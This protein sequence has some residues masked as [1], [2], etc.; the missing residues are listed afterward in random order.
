MPASPSSILG[1][2]DPAWPS[3]HAAN[4]IT[5]V[6]TYSESLQSQLQYHR[7]ATSRVLTE[8]Q[9][10]DSERLVRNLHGSFA[11]VYDTVV[12]LYQADMFW[13]V[14]GVERPNGKREDYASP[15][16]M[17]DLAEVWLAVIDRMI[18]FAASLSESEWERKIAYKSMAGVG[19]ESP[20][21]QMVV[22]V[23]NHGTHHRGQVTSMIRQLGEKP[24][25]L[26]LIAFY[27]EQEQG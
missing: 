8:V 24:V 12:H 11:S 2:G 27:R 22:H 14:G 4:E 10:L 6:V 9:Q 16:C 26:D 23:V 18:A 5:V 20:I 17:Y 15:G 21:W 25:S 19:Y 1:K 13:V 3:A 7:W